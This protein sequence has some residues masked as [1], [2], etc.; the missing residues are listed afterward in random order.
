LINQVVKH[1]REFLLSHHNAKAFILSSSIIQI[2][3]VCNQQD[4]QRFST[5]LYTSGYSFLVASLAH[6][7]EKTN[8]FS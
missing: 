7:N 1:I 4:I 2:L 5:I 6:E 3:G 8:S